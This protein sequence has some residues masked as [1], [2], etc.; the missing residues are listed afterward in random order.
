MGADIHIYAER[1]LKNGSWAAVSDFS[2]KTNTVFNEAPPKNG[3]PWFWPKINSRN[4]DFFAELA[5]V[6][7]DGA[8]PRGLPDD[9]SPLVAEEAILWS[10][11]GHSHSWMSAREF[12]PIF[13]RHHMTKDEVVKAIKDRVGGN[14]AEET[15]ANVVEDHIGIRV[16]E[17]NAKYAFDNL[18]FVFWFDN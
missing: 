9:V 8:E 15:L 2:Y 6:R 13:M 18:R 14:S 16:P 7:G 12:V 11:D 1:K 3:S 10:G 4:Y 5:S 17:E